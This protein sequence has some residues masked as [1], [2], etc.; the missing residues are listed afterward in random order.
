M[1]TLTVLILSL[2]QF[3]LFL[4]F[5]LQQKITVCPTYKATSLM[6][7]CCFH[8]L[9]SKLYSVLITWKSDSLMWVIYG[10]YKTKKTSTIGQYRS[11]F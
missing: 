6:L 7:I 3:L 1:G 2:R 5:G 8:I 10:K 4:Q 9:K 11:T